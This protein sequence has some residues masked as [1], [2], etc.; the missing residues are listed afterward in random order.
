[1]RNWWLTEK[2]I[3]MN[4][5]MSCIIMLFLK[6]SK[7]YNIT[8]YIYK[9]SISHTWTHT[10]SKSPGFPCLAEGKQMENM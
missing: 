10:I 3:H 4:Y 7:K 9:S 6:Q 1:M 8:Q 5:F 2:Q